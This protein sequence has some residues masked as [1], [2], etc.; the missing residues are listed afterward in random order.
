MSRIFR[1]Y[2][3]RSLPG[4]GAGL[5]LVLLSILILPAL[6]VVDD[7][8]TL[9]YF[10]LVV[11]L[12]ALAVILGSLNGTESASESRIEAEAAL[13]VS[14][15][16][17]QA[18]AALAALAAVSAAALIMV[19]LL[20]LLNEDGGLNNIR[21]S[22]GIGAY[23]LAL[24]QACAYSFVFG[25]MSRSL[26]A[27]AAAGAALALLTTMGI[28]ASTVV[29]ASVIGDA[30]GIPLKVLMFALAGVCA[31]LSLKYIASMSDRKQRPGARNII[32]VILLLS[33]G[34]IASGLLLGVSKARAHRLLVQARA[35]DRPFAGFISADNM[36]DVAF[37][38]YENP[39]RGELTLAQPDGRLRV[40]LP[41]K[42]KKIGEFLRN[43]MYYMTEASLVSPEGEV[44]VVRREQGYALYHAAPGGPLE[45]SAE[46]GLKDRPL[47][48]IFTAGSK[49]YMAMTRGYGDGMHYLAALVPGK[50]VK[51]ELTGQTKEAARDAV[52]KMKKASGRYAWLSKDK[53]LLMA[54]A[55]G[56]EAAVCRLP[57][58]GAP[59]YHSPLYEA[60][61]AGGRDLFFFPLI[62][63][64][65]TA[66]HYCERGKTAV[67]AWDAPEGYGF[68][69]RTSHDGSA[70]AASSRRVDGEDEWRVF[71]VIND[72]GEMLPPID[73]D[74]VFAGRPFKWALPVK[75]AGKEVF[76]MLDGKELVKTDG[77]KTT[78]IAGLD[79]RPGDAAVTGAGVLFRN[80]AGLH[81]AGWDGKK[82]LVN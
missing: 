26:L 75:A 28:L 7:R 5:A 6:K 55:G 39:V 53:Q 19:M 40:L 62:K 45:L 21:T 76:F 2:F 78:S 81:L 70:F 9:L 64:G 60:V 30:R 73:A 36:H 32:P 23:L 79:G 66:L 42:T 14:A 1:L 63:N 51:W 10:A 24:L 68:D 12:P 13:P 8:S 56:R 80:R 27:G 38:L 43:P 46:L 37:K 50:P 71:Y 44:W 16:K 31:L 11:L 58:K 25:R 17:R 65:K 4:V 3:M 74:K 67:P 34:L 72:S 20:T 29:D 49:T 48:A 69:F 18:G 82:R 77:N 54:M 15:F 57:H 33:A 61:K 59:F 35:G 22:L 47:L 52:I 41:G